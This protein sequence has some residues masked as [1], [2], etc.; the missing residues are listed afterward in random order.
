MDEWPASHTG[1]WDSAI[2][3]SSG[4]QQTLLHVLC[5]QAS[6]CVGI[7]SLNA[8]RNTS[9]VLDCVVVNLSGKLALKA[10]CP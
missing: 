2:K 10:E 7:E 5:G 6:R 4:L 3:G 1:I 9:G 8:H